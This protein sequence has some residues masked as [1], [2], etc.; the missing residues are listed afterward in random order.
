MDKSSAHNCSKVASVIAAPYVFDLERTVDKCC[1]LLDE[2]AANGA[3]LVVF[4]ETFLPMYPW[5]IWMAV[6]NVKRLELYKRLLAQSVHL[7][8]PALQRLCQRAKALGVYVVIG[9]NE[10]GGTTLYNS[11]VFIDETGQ[12]AGCRRKL[13]P[14]GEER[15][16]WGRGD[17]SDLFV[18]ETHLGRLGGLVCYENTMALSRYV[19]YSMGE[20]LHVAN[21][22][23]SDFK[24]QPRDRTRVIDTISR[25]IALEGQ[26]F[27]ISSSSCIGQDELEF[28]RQVDPTTDGK[29]DVGGGIAGIYSPFG[30]PVSEPII[31]VEGICYGEIDLERIAEAKHLIDCVGHYARPD[32]A[33]VVF[34]AH[35]QRPI[36]TSPATRGVQGF[37]ECAEASSVVP[38]E[39]T[40]D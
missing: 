13:V 19:L 39:N 40:I 34:N 28:Y 37:D 5:W 35:K 15:T 38:T 26:M 23:G 18:L 2:A 3:E 21:W 4:P 25:F 9:I 8:G 24:S 12:I 7:E 32:V 14:T 29:L 17:G 6:D 20:Q 27:V 33:H 36:V 22:P 30:D 11:Q 31:G 16:V 1:A 10:L